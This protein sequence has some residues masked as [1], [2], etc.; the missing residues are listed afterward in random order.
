MILSSMKMKYKIPD[1]F[2]D[3]LKAGILVLLLMLAGFTFLVYHTKVR[4]CV[5]SGQ[6]MLP[7]FTDETRLLIQKKADIRR[8]D[9]IV[10]QLNDDYLIKRVIGLPGDR[11]TV[12]NGTLF[13]NG[14]RVNEPYLE[15]SYVQAFSQEQFQTYITEDTYFVMGD[16]RDNSMDSRKL[17][18]I[19]K[20][21]I[22]G[23]PIMKLN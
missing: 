4:T 22:V 14:E 15:D 23:V 5:V 11:I 19:A 16:N 17:G 18:T 9:V 2:K 13:V 20:E 8:F 1:W 6:S 3:M 12:E 10:F 7:T 21:Q